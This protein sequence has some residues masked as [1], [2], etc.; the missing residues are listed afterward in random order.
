MVSPRRPRCQVLRRLVW[1]S[2]EPPSKPGP[3]WQVQTPLVLL[4]ALRQSWPE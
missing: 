4:P 2:L 1:W 3:V